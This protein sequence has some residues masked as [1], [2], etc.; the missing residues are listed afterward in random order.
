MKPVTK[1]HLNAIKQWCLKAITR[2]TEINYYSARGFYKYLL[3]RSNRRYKG[4]L[5]LIY[6]MG[7]VGSKTVERSLRAIKLDMP[8]Y[9]THLLTKERIA[10]TEAKRKKFFRTERYSYLKRPWLNQFLLK[11]IE[12]DLNDKKWKILT[13]TREPIARNISTF[14]ENLEVKLIDS[15]DKYE[16]KSDYYDIEPIIVTPDNMLE[17][18][19]LFFARLNHDSPLVFFDRELKGVFGIDVF[20]S[21]FSKSK[22]FKIYGVL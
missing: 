20:A 19:D 6:Q 16:V 13:L 22:G 4:P 5:L 21:E 1:P 15:S 12:S 14:F 7:K 8:I 11:Q 18:R 17:L 10:D 3:H 9:H 2:L